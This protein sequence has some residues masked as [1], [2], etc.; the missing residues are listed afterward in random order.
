MAQAVR[1]SPPTAGV[2]SS[3]LGHS[4]WVSWGTKRGLGRFFAGFFTLFPL[5]QISFHHFSTLISSISFHFNSSCDGTSGEP[6]TDLQYRGFIASHPSTRP[7]VGHE[8][9][10]FIFL[11][12]LINNGNNFL[13]IL[14]YGFKQKGKQLQKQDFKTLRG[15]LFYLYHLFWLSLLNRDSQL[16][17]IIHG[18]KNKYC[19][20]I[21][22]YLYNINIFILFSIRL[23]TQ[24]L[25][26][27]NKF[28]QIRYLGPFCNYL[29]PVLFIFDLPLILRVPRV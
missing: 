7:C 10:I 18:G 25:N 11:L 2:P 14:I 24:R 28:V 12:F 29:Q 23:L 6:F 27:V 4:M 16:W 20:I 15:L 5:P 1:R 3:R 9:R 22:L 21:S 19:I 17:W 26:Q 8:L 13:L